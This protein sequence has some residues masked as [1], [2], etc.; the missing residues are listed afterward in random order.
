MLYYPWSYR[1]T[2]DESLILL[3]R[4][5]VLSY[6][7]LRLT[8]VMFE[9]SL[10]SFQYNNKGRRLSNYLIK[11]ILCSHRRSRCK[12]LFQ[13]KK[14]GFDQY[15]K[16]GHFCAAHMAFQNA[17]FWS[18]CDVTDLQDTMIRLIIHDKYKKSRCVCE[19]LNMP[20]VAT[21]SKKSIFS[22]KVKV[23]VTRS[24][25]LVSFERASLVEYACHI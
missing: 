14:H 22:A 19:T 20:P 10:K 5:C 8:K 2:I 7:C 24:L 17:S 21:K 6:L 23:K 16:G 3:K 4:I 12:G 11:L 25:I 1:I 15:T 18:F 13:N 9:T